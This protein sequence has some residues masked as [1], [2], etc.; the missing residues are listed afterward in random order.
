M[1]GDWIK[2]RDNLWSDPRVSRLCDLTGKGKAAVI[3][4]LYWL[5]SNADQHSVDG[6]MPGLTTKGV[7]RETGIPGFGKALTDPNVRW[8]EDGPSWVSIPKF[9]EHNG[10]SAKT[11]AEGS[12]RKANWRKR[13]TRDGA[14]VPQSTGQLSTGSQDKGGTD[15]GQ[16]GDNREAREEKRREENL[17]E[18]PTVIDT[19]RAEHQPLALAE[20]GI[21]PD[22]PAAIL[23]SVC[24]ANGIKATPFHP[25]VVEWARDGFTVDA[26][27]EAIARARLRKGEAS[28]PVAYL[29]PIL[30]DDAKPVDS[31]WRQDDGKAEALAK[32]L[33]IKGAKTGEDRATFHARIDQALADRARRQVA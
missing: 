31:G 25:L 12:K 24:V 2:M 26:I 4:G 13:N 5:W 1:A 22:T 16:I 11:R 21:D 8:L 20:A 19:P 23:A 9:D 14:S 7:D 17:E 30:R 18:H 27:K 28:I 29:D 3:G 33:G 10:E 15:A 6:M 32:E